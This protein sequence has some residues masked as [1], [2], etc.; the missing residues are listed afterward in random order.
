MLDDKLQCD[1]FSDDSGDE[2]VNW[3]STGKGK[4]IGKGK[5]RI[6][7]LSFSGTS[8]ESDD[9]TIDVYENIAIDDSIV[10]PVFCWPLEFDD[11]Q[12]LE[13]PADFPTI[14]DAVM[15]R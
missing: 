7:E 6:D 9:G 4:S 13:I 1:N 2:S 15:N 11:V 12:P 8:S 14:S 3:N 10:D 5:R